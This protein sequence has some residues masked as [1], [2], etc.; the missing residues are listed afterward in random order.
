MTGYGFSS[1]GG[2][3]F[4]DLG[5]LPNNNCSN[6]T[7]WSGDPSVGTYSNSGFTYFY[8]SSLYSCNLF[9]GCPLAGLPMDGLAVALSACQVTGNTLRLWPAHHC[10]Y[11]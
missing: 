8:V 3:S 9:P 2:N 10:G 4:T 1:D 7:R 11:R 6:G 5:G